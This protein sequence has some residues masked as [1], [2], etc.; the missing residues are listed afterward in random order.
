MSVAP[1]SVNQVGHRVG[2]QNLVGRR[3][4]RPASG[5]FQ[6]TAHAGTGRSQIVSDIIRGLLDLVH[7]HTNAIEHRIEVFCQLI[8]FIVLATQRRA[9]AQAT[10]HDRHGLS[11]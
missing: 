6:S 9:L 11:R 5:A 1:P 2:D 10:L 7:Q 3:I 8:P 4:A